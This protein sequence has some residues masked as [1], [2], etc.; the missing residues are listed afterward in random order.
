MS[1]GE[2]NLI[3]ERWI[4]VLDTDGTV[5]EVSME[6]LFKRAHEIRSLAGELPT[7]DFAVMRLMLA[8]LYAVYLRQ[9]VHGNQL[10]MRNEDDALEQWDSI[11][12]A[13]R[14][15]SEQILGY[16][17]GYK[18]RF[19]LFHPERPFYQV[20]LDK[21]SDYKAA[22][23]IGDISESNNKKRLFSSRNGEP[24]E[25]VGFAEAARWLLHV[26]AYDDTSGKPTRRKSGLPSVGIGWLG[27]LG[28]V[29]VQGKNLFETLVLNMVLADSDGEP[30]SA[31][32]A[33]WE[34]DIVCREERREIPRPGHIL[35][36]LTLQS[37]RMILMREGP[38]ITGY[39]LIGGDVFPKDNAFI[40]QMTAWRSPDKSGQTW[41]PKR[42]DPARQVWRDYSSLVMRSSD[43]DSEF[44]RAPGVV[45]WMS[46]LVYEGLYS[47]GSV[48]LGTVGA[49]YGDKNTLLEGTVDDNLVLN[50][51]LLTEM[52]REWNVRINDVIKKTD[53]CVDTL[54]R[55]AINM[56]KAGGNSDGNSHTKIAA[57]T[58]TGAFHRLDEPFRRWLR[59]IDPKRKDSMDEQ[60]EVWIRA[61]RSTV[62]GIGRK[63]LS[64][65]SDSALVGRS[66]KENAFAIFRLFE[67]T[68]YK[69]T[70]GA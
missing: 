21:G 52:G 65:S 3:H 26:N 6:D 35:D 7:Q 10:R 54:G 20:H 13:G 56:E 40:E 34:S 4:R 58:R 16:L 25:S 24:K 48:H 62:L 69:K 19:Y 70:R 60:M 41:T 36:L 63:M 14:F 47:E 33:V 15:D 39:L 49:K 53:D 9:D 28:S 32:E 42:H 23:L 37:R 45:G 57:E 27:E 17:D 22:K 68:I 11:W 5:E 30:L 2:F 64:E 46:S 44:Y 55:F 8:V 12:S 1:E 61:M 59:E 43:T 66:F 29:Y 38:A 50:G 31:G 18:D 67:N 51:N